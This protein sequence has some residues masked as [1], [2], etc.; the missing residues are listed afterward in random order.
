M[1]SDI[2]YDC[3]W[4]GKV[5][6]H[7]MEDFLQVQNEV[8]HHGTKEDFIRQFTNNIYGE[9]VIVVVYIDHRPVAARA[10]WRNDIYGKE[11]YQPG[12]T[13]VLEI[14]RGRGIF[15]EM[16]ERA[17]DMLP[18][19]AIVYNFPNPYSY[20]GYIK[21]GWTLLHDYKMRLFIS[22]KAYIHEHPVKIDDEYFEWWLKGR[23]LTY[24]HRK[25]HF[26]LLNKDHRPFC[27]R[28]LGEVSETAAKCFPQTRIGLFFYKSTRQTWYN[29]RQLYSHV[30]TRNP[31]VG[32]IPTWK[33]DAIG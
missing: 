26:F 28:I 20:P 7:F 5:D 27:Y 14:C 10:L 8:F 4:S 3:R 6:N 23:T 33:I 16:T 30:V 2:K 31:E 17:L 29:K 19:G 9:S 32:Y 15:T 13:C 1:E 18:T 25:G 21:M 12:S 11:A 22:Y 24:M